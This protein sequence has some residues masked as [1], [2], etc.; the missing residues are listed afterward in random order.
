MINYKGYYID[1][2]T[3]NS[4]EEIDNFLEEQAVKAYKQA[5]ELFAVHPDMEHS[6]YADDRAEYLVS[7]FGYTWEQVE[8][9]E[10]ATLKAIA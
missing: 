8:E 2:I 6:A 4:K 3:F 9:L 5:V 1:N 10:I 7:Q